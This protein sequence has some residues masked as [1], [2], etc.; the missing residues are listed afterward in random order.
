MVP[1]KPSVR[2]KSKHWNQ[3]PK[4]KTSHTVEDS[5]F[6]K[7]RRLM[8]YDKIEQFDHVM[9]TTK[10]ILAHGRILKKRRF[11]LEKAEQDLRDKAKLCGID[12]DQ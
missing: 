8:G 12:L 9:L 3:P 4:R 1:P 5:K 10:R 7:F 11:E 2:C 6:H